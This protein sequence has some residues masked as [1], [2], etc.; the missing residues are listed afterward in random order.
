M[1][2]AM[3]LGLKMPVPTISIGTG[4]CSF[5]RGS[6]HFSSP[7]STISNIG[8][9]S[10]LS[11]FTV[12]AMKKL[13]GKVVCSTN[14]KTVKVEV[15]RLAVYPKYK[16]IVRKKKRYQAHD[17]DNKFKVGDL[18]ELEKCK[19]ISKTKT[20]LALPVPPRANSPPKT[21]TPPEELSLLLE[22][23]ATLS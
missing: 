10:N 18:V 17:P 9:T 7:N 1:A 14:D 23:S 20:F 6:T 3:G 8:S 4:Q 11:Q 19:P 12:R 2:M 22:S 21:K 15:V 5:L 13:Q 16:K